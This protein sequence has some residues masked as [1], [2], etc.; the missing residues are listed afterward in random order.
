MH[1]NSGGMVATR[2]RF[3]RRT[4]CKGNGSVVLACVVNNDAATGP[5]I[6]AAPTRLLRE[7]TG[8]T[9]DSFCIQYEVTSA[10]VS[11][12]SRVNAGGGPARG[13]RGA[14]RGARGQEGGADRPAVAPPAGAAANFPRRSD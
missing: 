8:A 12:S 4:P 13:N 14:R 9:A 1:S 7:R 6:T 3:A 2:A 5:P 10:E 11:A